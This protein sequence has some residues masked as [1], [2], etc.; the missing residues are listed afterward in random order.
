[1]CQFLI[2]SYGPRDYRLMLLYL[3]RYDLCRLKLITND[4]Y[5][6]MSD[7]TAIVNVYKRPHTLDVQIKAILA[8]T[9]PPKCIFI[10]N[11]GNDVDLTSYKDNPIIRIFNASHNFGVWS[12]F[13]I[14][15]LAPTNYI[16]IFDD[17]TIPGNR[18]FEN[19]IRT[20]GEREA[21]LCTIGVILNADD[22]YQHLKRYG[23][24]GPS[25]KSMPVDIPGH[26]WF[27]KKEWLSYF[28]REPPQVH[29]RISSGEDIHFAFM[30]QKYANIPVY[31]PP[32]PPHDISLWGSIPA[33]AWAYG[34]DGNSETGNYTP[35]D[36]TLREYIARG[37]RVMMQRYKYTMTDDLI[38]FLGMIRERKPFAI[39][40][41]ADGEYAVLQNQTLTN[42]DNW[43]FRTGGRLSTDLRNALILAQKTCAYIGIPCGDCNLAMCKWYIDTFELNPQYT[44]FAN[45]FVNNN[46][47]AWV[48]FLEKEQVQFTH[49]GCGTN[50]TKFAVQKSITIDPYL[51][52][53]WDS[54]ADET[55]A[56]IL[57]EV[58]KVTGAV[59]M[60]SGGP[61]AKI[62]IA[63]AWEVHPHNIYIDIGSSLDLFFKGTTNRYYT[64][65]SDG[66]ASLVCKFT[67]ESICL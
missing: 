31:V 25:A 62:L 2:D 4:I 23:W 27:F 59:F 15:F 49:I 3:Y 58:Q 33:T 35:L 6:T 43:T 30:L 48:D 22:R 1:L 60:F 28:V 65:A 24:D 44:T 45:I 51:V 8:Q 5:I 63:R 55:I 14:G 29:E 39:I 61:I 67:T 42:V 41:P 9:V 32:H 21:L 16:C 13:L 66:L 40:R 11:N 36:I 53:E 50:V 47:K 10:W 34:L 64:L 37:F 46:W 26:S 7:I 18:W 12:R 56:N 57:L 17:D 38:R 19:C 54:K 52:N 20:M